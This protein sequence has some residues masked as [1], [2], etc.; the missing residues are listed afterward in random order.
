MAQF[1]ESIVAGVSMNRSLGSF[2]RACEVYI[3]KES[4]KLLPDNA[5]VSL[6]CDAVRLTR[7]LMIADARRSV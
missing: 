1:D 2:I 4:Q 7:E 6:L 5:L 3:Q